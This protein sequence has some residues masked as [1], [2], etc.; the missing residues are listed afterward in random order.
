MDADIQL[1]SYSDAGV[2]LTLAPAAKPIPGT[3]QDKPR[4]IRPDFVLFR[5]APFGV[6]GQ[7]WRNTLIGLVHSRT[8]CMFVQ[9][10]PTLLCVVANDV[11]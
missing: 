3:N 9:Q 5:S 7:D 11:A 8:P 10:T 6:I 1:V 2:V 4:T